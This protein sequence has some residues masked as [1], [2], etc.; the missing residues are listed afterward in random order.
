MR[1]VASEHESQ[2]SRRGRS[3]QRAAALRKWRLRSVAMER[4]EAR[5][6]LATLPAPLVTQHPYN[7]NGGNQYAIDNISANNGVGGND[8]TPS[9]A[10]DPQNSKNLVAVWVTDNPSRPLRSSGANNTT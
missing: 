9:V 7:P 3:G 1:T 4:L 6:L 10:V 5:E 2:G 8:S